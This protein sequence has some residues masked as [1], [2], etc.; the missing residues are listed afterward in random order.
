MRW[1]AQNVDADDDGRLPGLGDTV[2]RRFDAPEALDMRF[3]EIRTKSALN[4][5]PGGTTGL[6][7]EWTI[8]PYRGCTHACVYC[9]APDTPILL[10]SGRTRRIADLRPG[11]EI[12]GTVRQ[13]A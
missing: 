4:H 7:F 12:N 1:A 13:G 10:A 3:H 2:I 9:A 6:P 5:V 11:D 8:N